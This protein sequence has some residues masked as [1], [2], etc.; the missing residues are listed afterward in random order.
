M[1]TTAVPVTKVD[2]VRHTVAIYSHNRMTVNQV[3]WLLNEAGHRL[4]TIQHKS[5]VENVIV[6]EAATLLVLDLPQPKT[7]DF[8]L[9]RRMVERYKIPLLII[10]RDGSPA[11]R[12]SS[13]QAGA[14]DYVSDPFYLEELW[15]RMRNLMERQT[16]Q[17]APGAS[18]DEIMELGGGVVLDVISRELRRGNYTL[19]LT[20][21]EFRLMRFM[22]LNAGRLLSLSTLSEVGWGQAGPARDELYVYIAALRRKLGGRLAAPAR[23]ESRRGEGYIFFKG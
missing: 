4:V 13:L 3:S 17:Q 12:I 6:A 1:I 8:E 21:I 23:I 22:V 20:P 5:D 10:S 9:C 18:R 16:A 14:L 19:R 15:M 11:T 2:R 7:Q